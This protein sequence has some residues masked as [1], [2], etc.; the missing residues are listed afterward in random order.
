ME[1]SVSLTREEKPNCFFYDKK[2]NCF[3]YVELGLLT[4]LIMFIIL[5]FVERS[6]NPDINAIQDLLFIVIFLLSIIFSYIFL[7]QNG[8]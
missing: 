6:K 5:C 7:K 2:P 8:R 4:D 1:K 3:F